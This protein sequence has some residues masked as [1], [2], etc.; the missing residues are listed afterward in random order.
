MKRTISKI[1]NQRKMKTKA[2]IVT[3]AGSGTGRATAFRLKGFIVYEVSAER[4]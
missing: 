2:V 4:C 1:K 3:G